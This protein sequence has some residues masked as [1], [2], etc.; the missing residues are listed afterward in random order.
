MRL[1]AKGLT[2]AGLAALAVALVATPLGTGSASSGETVESAT[3]KPG[4][5]GPRGPRGFRGR[6]GSRGLN[7][8]QGA[9]GAAGPAGQPGPT[10][11][12]G[13]RG[14]PGEPGPPG[15]GLTR[16]GFTITLIDPAGSE[17]SMA[18]GADGLALI[19]YRAGDLKVAH[20]ENI[21]CT[22]AALS[23]VDTDALVDS[24]SLAIGS[25]G[26]GLIS[27]FDKSG[28]RVAHCRNRSCSDSTIATI[29][30]GSGPPSIVIGAD[31]LGLITY[32]NGEFVE[33]A[34]CHDVACST[35]STE[36]ISAGFGAGPSS[37][38]IGADGL[39][40]I[41]YPHELKGG[42]TVEIAH[43]VDVTCSSRT[44]ASVGTGVIRYYSAIT[45]GSDGLALFPIVG[46]D[47]GLL[48]I[49][50]CSNTGCSVVNG[51][52]TL[53]DFVNGV[54][55]TV[56]ADGLAYAA[57]PRGGDPEPFGISLVHCR[58]IPCTSTSTTSVVPGF[59]AHGPVSIAVGV[60][61]FPLL[62]Y[63]H[64][65]LEVA[66]CSNVLCVPHFRRR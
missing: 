36:T 28:L 57:V 27:Y 31:G 22:Q 48:D 43:C 30:T 29:T 41:A 17:P 13:P 14:L 8:P 52:G 16:P 54:A 47:N 21:G 50:H 39:G 64:N 6:R 37:V 55:M 45:I 4:P 20:C 18:I 56:G 51:T 23:L 2:L 25:D 34:H 7:G 1:S 61:A 15:L 11:A 10:G 58:D 66:H 59:E 60:D 32:R 49:E 19:A 5:R 63:V 53:A 12:T 9:A 35:A 65:G 3:A 40:L 38:T 62:A 33:V 44:I 42:M 24:I 46:S 26:L